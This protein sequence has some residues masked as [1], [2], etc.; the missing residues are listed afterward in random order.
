MSVKT[1]FGTAYKDY[2]GYMRISSVKGG[3]H[4]KLVHRLVFEDFYKIKLPADVIIHHN[5]G[6]KT[7]NEIWNL[8][9]LTNEEH[10]RMHHTGAV[11][12]E[13]RCRRI[14]E[15]KK[16]F[17]YSEESKQKMREA[18]L[19]KHQPLE[20][21]VN[22]SRT[23]NKMGLFRVFKSQNKSCKQGFDYCYNYTEN[24]KRKEIHSIDILKLKKRVIEKGLPWIVVD[25]NKLKL[26][27]G[28]VLAKKI[29]KAIGE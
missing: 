23:N 4:N 3:N 27:F 19:G 20:M 8:I 11:F 17:K 28:D 15:A 2:H 13:E 6:D 5:D 12:T 26:E 22:R 14:S 18:K 24:N 1:K 9:P 29:L 16:G 10:S 7:N 21:V 25:E